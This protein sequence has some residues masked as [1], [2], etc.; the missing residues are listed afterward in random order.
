MCPNSKAF[1]G[2]QWH[3]YPSLQ[4]GHYR[5]HA[6]RFLASVNWPALIEYAT[7]K[8]NGINCV[9]LPDIGL[10]LNNMVRI[11]EFADGLRWVARL[12]MPPLAESTSCEDTPNTKMNREFHAI[13]LVQQKTR[14]PV[15][16]IY[17]LESGGD[18]SVRAPFMLMDCLEGNV[19]MDLG[20]EIP[21]ESKQT[22][23]SDL[24]KIH[25]QLSKVQLPMIGTILS[26]NTDGS[27][28]QGPIPGL[29][30]P[31]NAATQFF[32]T[33]AA[34]VRFGMPDERLRAACGQY[35]TEIIHSVETFPKS[36]CDLANRLSL[37]DHGPF[38]LCHV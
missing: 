28:Q 16:Q 6:D 24:A 4:A 10:G 3:Y 37:R 9:L 29:G 35:A 14:V 2:Y 20:K 25:V 21:P 17:A 19:A 11:L 36:I 30:G 31:F 22:A 8:R 15:P 33:W 27:Y 34:K 38:P 32:E 7:E 18:C 12:Q 26:I 23:L 1:S 5:S 13:S